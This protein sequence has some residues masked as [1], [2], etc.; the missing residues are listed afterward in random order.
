MRTPYIGSPRA[1]SGRP[2]PAARERSPIVCRPLS[3]RPRGSS[4]R[5]LSSS[6]RPLSSRVVVVR[7]GRTA[8]NARGLFQGQADPPLDSA[9]WC[10]AWRAAA[11][12]GVFAPAAVVSSD[13]LRARQTACCIAL[14]AEVDV[15][16]DPALREQDVGGWE[17]LTGLDASVAYPAEHL[18]WR[19]GLGPRRGGGE[20]EAEAGERVADALRRAMGACPAG[21]SIVVVSHGVIIQSALRQL[22]GP[23]PTVHLANGQW[24]ALPV[25]RVEG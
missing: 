5:P 19:A 13:L 4:R 2:R 23:L 16:L 14:C 9:G 25:R 18:A 20:T 11:E 24:V 12:L 15:L 8:W 21:R 6:S 22:R 10:Q 3:D 7:H 1:P 17:G